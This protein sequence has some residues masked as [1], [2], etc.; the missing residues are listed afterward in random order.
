MRGYFGIGIVNLKKDINIGS[1]WRSAYIF[2]AAFIFATG[3][4]YS[5]QA[6][7]TTKSSRHIPLFHYETNTDFL[8][9]RPFDC[10]LIGIELGDEYTPL[11]NFQHP[12][13]AIY[14]LGSEDGGLPNEVLDH[15]QYVI[16]I[17]TIVPHSINVA[18]AGSVV[19]YDRLSK[20]KEVTCQ[21]I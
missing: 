3:Q 6:S 7:D 2:G 19:M 18:V 17:P 13:K 4:R 20:F 1:L 21:N 12:E 11:P 16:Q 14:V 8:Q 10:P 9:H 15:C 5:K